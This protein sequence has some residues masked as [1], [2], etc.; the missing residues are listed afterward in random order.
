MTTDGPKNAC[1]AAYCGVCAEAARKKTQPP[2]EE[3]ADMPRP[4][5]KPAPKSAPA[6]VKGSG[7]RRNQRLQESRDRFGNVS[8]SGTAHKPPW[9]RDC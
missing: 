8:K 4:P 1:S 3:S 7:Q 2:T 9:Y 5:S 6:P